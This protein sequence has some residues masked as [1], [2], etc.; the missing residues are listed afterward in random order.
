MRIVKTF[1]H[2]LLT[3][4]MCECKG[5]LLLSG[6]RGNKYRPR[7]QP[8]GPSDISNYYTSFNVHQSSYGTTFGR[9]RLD[10]NTHI[11]NDNFKNYKESGE[12]FLTESLYQEQEGKSELR[13][14][15]ERFDRRWRSTTKS[16]YFKNQVPSENSKL[17]AAV[18]VGKFQEKKNLL[19]K[20]IVDFHRQ[21]LQKHLDLKPCCL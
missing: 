16:P 19:H 21:L 14:W 4:T 5:V 10:S 17:P 9:N 6:S 8:Y 7:F 15:S 12:N 3:I 2:L 1:V 13:G 18:V 11:Y 20:M